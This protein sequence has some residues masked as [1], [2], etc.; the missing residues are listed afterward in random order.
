MHIRTM[1][2][3]TYNMYKTHSINHSLHQ[4]DRFNL[5]IT[6]HKGNAVSVKIK[7]TH[8]VHLTLFFLNIGG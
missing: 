2:T 1:N 3:L 8:D 7:P 4:S 5:N 6:P